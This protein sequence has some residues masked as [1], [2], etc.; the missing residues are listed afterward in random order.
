MVVPVVAG[1][2][3]SSILLVDYLRP[4]P[5]FCSTGGGC[6]IVR[7][8]AFAS[9]L[10]VPTPVV[11]LL[12]FAAIAALVLCVGPRA[13]AAHLAVAGTGAVVALFLLLVQLRLGVLCAY[14]FIADSSALVAAAV[15]AWRAHGA[16]DLPGR[17]L[18][19][20]LAL[21]AL[22]LAV[23]VPGA[24]G[25]TAPR[26]AAAAPAVIEAEIQKTPKGQATVVD[27]VDFECPFC[28]MAQKEFSPALAANRSHVRL[29]RKQVP[30][31]H[32]HPH[33]LDAARAACCGEKLGKGDAMAD[34]LFEAP[35]D[36]LTPP[37]CEKIAERLGLP[38]DAYR[39]CVSDPR[40]DAQI[41]ADRAMFKAAD[42]HGLPTI[43]INEQKFEGLQ[44]E[45]TLS[46]ALDSAIAGKGS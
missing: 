36:D 24:I 37:G 16:W 39:A 42:G 8:T 45:G 34:A 18:T 14:C 20:G 21:G 22:G 9:V 33:A 2:L 41:E 1:L 28:R 4:A 32:I 35:V 30:L 3:A 25:L 7:R 38:V 46:K 26:A 29:V 11:G 13:R 40:T 12:G 31:T 27:F 19:R 44:P 10:G 15:A 5:L 6:D 43:W 17:R 23:F